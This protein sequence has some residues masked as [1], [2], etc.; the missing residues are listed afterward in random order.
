MLVQD[1]VNVPTRRHT[2]V[3]FVQ[4]WTC[5]CTSRDLQRHG[6]CG[7][8]KRKELGAWSSRRRRDVELPRNLACALGTRDAEPSCSLGA[9]LAQ[10][11]ADVICPEPGRSE[12]AKAS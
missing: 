12:L 9:S 7:V 4:A 5:D 1:A 6:L 11:V 8:H 3:C 2:L 10:Y